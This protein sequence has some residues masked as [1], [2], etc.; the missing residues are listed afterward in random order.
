MKVKHS[1]FKNTAILFELLVK[2]ITQEVLSNSTKNISEKIIKEFFSSNK[3]L[4]KELKLYNQIVKEKYSSID[5]AKLFLEEVSKERIKLDENKLN[6]EKYNLIKTIKESY[7]LNKFLSSNLQ[8]YKLLASVYKVFEAKTMGRKVEIRDFIESNNT[9]LEHITHKKISVKQ[10]DTLYESFKQQSE[11][12][13]L[14]TYKLLIENFNKKYSNLDDSQKG[15]KESK[16]INDKVTKIKI[17]EMIKLYK[18]DKFLKENQEKQVSVL[19]LTY[20][21]LKEVKNV[22]SARSVKK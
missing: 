19:M 1:K 11:D 15:L 22:N 3:E 5:D 7:D 9:I 6:K 4:A 20:E 14:L 16:G 2:Q 18:S 12:L 13:R 17:S 21:L 10:A 8:N